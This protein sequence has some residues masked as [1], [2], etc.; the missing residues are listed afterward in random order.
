MP[1]ISDSIFP[2]VFFGSLQV[3]GQILTS[4]LVPLLRQTTSSV[5]WKGSSRLKMPLLPCLIP[6][7]RSSPTFFDH[8]LMPQF[9]RYSALKMHEDFVSPKKDKNQDYFH[10]PRRGWGMNVTVEALLRLPTKKVLVSTIIM[11]F[12]SGGVW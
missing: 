10:L 9:L 2:R 6:T 1:P 8:D 5:E 3:A 11:I 7:R 12:F 4:N